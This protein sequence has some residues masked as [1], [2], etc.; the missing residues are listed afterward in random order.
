VNTSPFNIM[1]SPMAQA[2]RAP[3]PR[4][5]HSIV[6]R[7]LKDLVIDAVNS[8]KANAKDAPIPNLVASIE[9]NGILAPLIVKARS[10]GKF[11]II[12]GSRRYAAAK[13]LKM[14]VVPTV[15]V[16][17]GNVALSL[18]M[19]LSVQQMDHFQKYDAYKAG[20]AA[21]LDDLEIR[22]QLGF[23]ATNAKI[24]RALGSMD[25]QAMEAC[26]EVDA[27]PGLVLRMARI[28]VE[29]QAGVA[30]RARLEDLSIS[31]WK[32]RAAVD[33]FYSASRGEFRR[34]QISQL[35]PDYK[36]LGGRVIEPLFDLGDG[37]DGKPIDDH[38]LVDAYHA[39]MARAAD[40]HEKHWGYRPFIAKPG[41]YF[42]A[43]AMEQHGV[44]PVYPIITDKQREE[45]AIAAGFASFNDFSEQCDT[46]IEGDDPEFQ[47][48][49]DAYEAFLEASQVLPN[50]LAGI[51]MD[52]EGNINTV[53]NLVPVG[54]A[55]RAQ[56]AQ[57]TAPADNVEEAVEPVQGDI[58]DTAKRRRG[59]IY[60]SMVAEHM[61][62]SESFGLIM[63]AYSLY[64]A[65]A[66]AVG[67]YGVG[68]SHLRLSAGYSGGGDGSDYVLDQTRETMFATVELPDGTEPLEAF[69]RMPADHLVG[70]IVVCTA[71][72]QAETI[73]DS[74]FR[75]VVDSCNLPVRQMWDDVVDDVK[76]VDLWLRQ[77][78][79]DQLQDLADQID[80]DGIAIAKVVKASKKGDAVGALAK[81]LIGPNDAQPE[82]VRAL[83]ANTM[84]V[85][86]Y[87]SIPG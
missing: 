45:A 50:S 82:K 30:A 74:A 35:M 73:S 52:H 87:D 75:H 44:K 60:A 58:T 6:I 13:Q 38:L 47:R 7:S 11:S 68:T 43:T 55:A 53:H 20:I 56:G 69:T 65:A 59:V 1:E 16:E 77:F 61:A 31:D 71:V 19:N 84:P 10:D 14:P 21:G 24:A 2:Q 67:R 46:E 37:V 15:L 86:L 34:E 76:K 39:V 33:D 62:N 42:G 29:Y 85:G 41:L 48:K 80:P 26:R 49:V 81:A 57:Q 66:A 51:C 32:L 3:V 9:A 17:E 63:A 28:P 5:E 79:K 23:D 64:S 4:N 83:A 25:P 12:D 18:A 8:R 40:A 54:E 22:R 72:L 36:A 27:P 70:T 78:R